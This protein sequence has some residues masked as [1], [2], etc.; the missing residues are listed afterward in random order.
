MYLQRI[1]KIFVDY[2]NLQHNTTYTTKEFFDTIVFPLFYKHEKDMASY[3]NSPFHNPS[4]VTKAIKEQLIE[5]GNDSNVI[6]KL[7]PE[8]LKNEL[9]KYP[10]GV[11]KVKTKLLKK[12]HEKVSSKLADGSVIDASILLGGTCEEELNPT[13]SLV[14]NVNIPRD[15]EIVFATWVGA[16]FGVRVSGGL[17][18]AFEETAILDL[19]FQGWKHYRDFLDQTPNL[20]GNQIETWNGHWLAHALNSEYSSDNPLLNFNLK[21]ILKSDG[22]IDTIEWT[23]LIFSLAKKF[24][25]KEL[26]AYVYSLAQTNNTIGFIP[27]Y[28][29]EI[30]SF[31]DW[32]EKVSGQKVDNQNRFEEL[33]KKYIPKLSFEQSCQGGRIGIGSIEP[34]NLREYIAGKK[35]FS[36]KEYNKHTTDFYFYQAWIL[37][38]LNNT[39]LITMTEAVAKS[40]KAFAN[41]KRTTRNLNLVDTLLESNH[42]VKFIAAMADIVDN[43]DKEYRDQFNQL[44]NYV[45]QI[46]I[47]LFALFVALLRF[48]YLIIK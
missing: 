12:L 25:D 46:P 8:M 27:I 7:K 20:K 1:G 40:L 3:T 35:Q 47:D 23:D 24:R 5:Y 14:T 38:M 15:S 39:E 37:A 19:I 43:C 36:Q 10:D 11:S 30:D 34:K 42:R 28:L 17:V 45:L 44:V 18:L 41:E 6:N 32:Y 26:S 29:P 22:S 13:Y 16:G 33:K 2:Y 4:S 48:K 31:W 21:N 9:A